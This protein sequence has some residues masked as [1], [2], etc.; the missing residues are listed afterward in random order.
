MSIAAMP[1]AARIDRRAAVS[2]RLIDGFELSIDGAVVAASCATQRLIAFLAIHPRP[3]TRSYVAGSLWLDKTEHRA[4][5]NLRSS[6]WRTRDYGRRLIRTSRTHLQL[7]PDVYID[8]A[9]VDDIARN[10]LAGRIDGLLD[11]AQLLRGELLPDWYDDWVV[12]ERERLRQ[13]SLNAL[14]QLSSRWLALGRPTLAIDAALA[15]VS[16]E[17]LRESA[18]RALVDAHLAVGNAAEAVRQYRSYERLIH[19]G[20]GLTPSA[21]FTNRVASFIGD[22]V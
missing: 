2:V 9:K 10:L 21:A 12:V 16:A 13:L 15:A 22:A 8:V 20:M 11:G 6:L 3:L 5:S 18:H 7:A 14:E 19:E 17:P 1:L 4:T